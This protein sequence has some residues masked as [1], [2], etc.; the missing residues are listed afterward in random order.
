MLNFYRLPR[1]HHKRLKSM[2]L[3]ERLNEEIKRRTRVARAFPNPASRLRP[4]AF[5][6]K[7]SYHRSSVRADRAT[8]HK[9]P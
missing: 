5:P 2:N 1:Q 4:L 8:V 3:L 7:S 6:N 9:S